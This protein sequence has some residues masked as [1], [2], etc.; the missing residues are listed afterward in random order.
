MYW[1]ALKQRYL[2]PFYKQLHNKDCGPACIRMIARYYG[3]KFHPDY[4]NGISQLTEQG[5]S[6]HNIDKAAQQLG[7]LTISGATTIRQLTDTI[8]LPCILHWTASHFVVLYKINAKKGK[9]YLADPARG[10]HIV[11]NNTLRQNWLYD[12][13]K[14]YLLLL[15]PS[16]KFYTHIA[17]T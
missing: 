11:D 12:E 7:F 16:E 5:A 9:Y 2:F 6:L 15:S 10:K 14:G 8:P 1:T 4:L 13:E 17:N 3:R